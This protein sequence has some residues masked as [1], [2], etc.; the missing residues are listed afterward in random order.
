GVLMVEVKG[1]TIRIQNGQW[2]STSSTG[3]THPI[4]DPTQQAE[5]G[6]RA[7]R[8][9]L[10]KHD[11]TR[12]HEFA[13]FP[14]VALPDCRV[15]GDLR[16]DSPNELFIDI[17]HLHALP[18]RIEA[19]FA[20]A[21]QHADRQNQ[22]MGGQ[23]ALDALIAL[24][25]PTADLAPRLVEA[26][27]RE[28]RQI[29]A[30]TQQQFRVLKQLGQQRRAAILGGAGTGKTLLAMEKAERLANEGLRVLF[31]CYNKLLA[32]WVADRL[33]K[34]DLEVM[35]FH[36]LAGTL[37]ERAGNP[38][39]D[40]DPAD[41]FNRVADLLMDA[42]DTLRAADPSHAA[43][44]DAV[45]VD[46]GQD[47]DDT[48]WLCLTEALRRPDDGVFYVFYDP[49]QRVFAQVGQI[50]IPTP[51]FVLTEN[52]R[53]TQHIHAWLKPYMSDDLEA[54]GPDGRPVEVI[55][56][57]DPAE[58][59]KQLQKVLHRLVNVEGVAPA[60]IV[61]L[62][63]SAEKRS[64]WKNDEALG[65]FTL[66]WGAQA[67]TPMQVRVATIYAFKGMEAPVVIVSE[68]AAL[69]ADNWGKLMYV[70]VS[71]ARHHAVILGDP[72][73]PPSQP[74]V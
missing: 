16:P 13:L 57:P 30:L 7:L 58:E 4:H 49:R 35:T 6:R 10:S 32:Q 29:E 36:K 53:N 63:P 15:A 12:R 17:T 14:A 71:R 46:E 51:P 64:Q 55:P 52:L 39:A 42:L 28:N 54:A 66:T 74:P 38:T 65:N 62:T 11:K 26:F 68:L 69:R 23:G 31:V 45:V 50:P 20:F 61:I 47:F 2:Y 25:V 19:M 21:K 3:A 9:W 1:G 24:V 37:C 33:A 18:A 27:A 43:L 72:T 34:P 5:R 67:A 41:F 60:D 56:C 70:A 44:Y 48:W 40:L 73:P 59:R 22:R 8:Q